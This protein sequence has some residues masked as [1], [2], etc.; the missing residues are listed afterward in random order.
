MTY[1]IDNILKYIALALTIVLMGCN[2]KDEPDTGG[3]VD[4]ESVIAVP[5]RD[6]YV[7]DSEKGTLP[8]RLRATANSPQKSTP[9]IAIG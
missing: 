2:S 6:D 9:P 1:R 4:D 5:E 3:K 8:S 7:T